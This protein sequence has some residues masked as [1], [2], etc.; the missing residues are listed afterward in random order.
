[1]DQRLHKAERPEYCEP[2]LVYH[3]W[4]SYKT[5]ALGARFQVK[6]IIV[7]PDAESS[8]QIHHHRACQKD[9]KDACTALTRKKGSISEYALTFLKSLHCG[10]NPHFLRYVISRK[11]YKIKKC[12][13][14][15]IDIV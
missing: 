14:I 8:L 4:G 6:H 13:T 15:K 1:M 3:P 11:P 5:L 10:R 7:V 2:T 12:N 9:Q